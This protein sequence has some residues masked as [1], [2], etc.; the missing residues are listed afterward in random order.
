[1][2]V[3]YIYFLTHDMK[4]QSWRQV[5]FG[6]WVE[7]LLYWWIFIFA[8]FLIWLWAKW[9]QISFIKHIVITRMKFYMICLH[10]SQRLAWYLYI[11]HLIID[12]RLLFIEIILSHF[13]KHNAHLLWQILDLIHFFS[14]NIIYLLN[15]INII[16]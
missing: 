14:I 12:C 4:I 16:V 2:L 11:L 9:K 8:F 13:L 15:L 7:R 1:M 6:I 3:R 5:R 10:L